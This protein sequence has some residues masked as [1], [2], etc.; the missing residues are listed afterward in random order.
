MP[1]HYKRLWWSVDSN[2]TFLVFPSMNTERVVFARRMAV[3]QIPPAWGQ[4]LRDP[5]PPKTDKQRAWSAWCSPE[6]GIFGKVGNV[7]H[8]APKLSWQSMHLVS[9]RSWVRSP[10]GAFPNKKNRDFHTQKVIVFRG[11]ERSWE[12]CCGWTRVANMA[13][14]W[15]SVSP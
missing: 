12:S 3:R 15:H 11:G 2:V 9:V 4:Q 1:L 7:V 14:D 5:P 10:L 8:M 13:T 6:S